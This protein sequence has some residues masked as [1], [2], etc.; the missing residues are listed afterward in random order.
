VIGDKKKVFGDFGF[1]KERGGNS[2]ISV[3]LYCNICFINI[4]PENLYYY[5]TFQI[6]EFCFLIGG[7]KQED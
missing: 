7:A 5:N 1:G 3:Q 4:R 2:M 6:L